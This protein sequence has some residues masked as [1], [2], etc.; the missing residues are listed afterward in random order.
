[1][2]PTGALVAEL[3]DGD[4]ALAVSP[5]TEASIPMKSAIA[6]AFTNFMLALVVSTR[7]I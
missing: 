4:W 6:A 2:L 5:T 1:M 7:L 3:A